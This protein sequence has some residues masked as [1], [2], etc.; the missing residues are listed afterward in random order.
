MYQTGTDRKYERVFGFSSFSLD[1]TY[2]DDDGGIVSERSAEMDIKDPSK[3]ITVGID[4]DEQ[5]TYV[6]VMP[7]NGIVATD[8]Y[9]A[10]ET[11]STFAVKDMEEITIAV[12]ADGFGHVI[13]GAGEVLS[14]KTVGGAAASSL[15]LSD[16]D[17]TADMDI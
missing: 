4:L 9:P 7:L 8:Y 14:V 10:S 3:V 1:I 15:L 5:T 12:G 6:T 16:V 13:A 17:F 11:V 2:Y